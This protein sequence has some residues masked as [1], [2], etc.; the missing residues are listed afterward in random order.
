MIER[1]RRWN[2]FL[3]V[4]GVISGIVFGLLWKL[5]GSSWAEAIL[6]GAG[7]GFLVVVGRQLVLIALA[8]SAERDARVR[9]QG[10]EHEWISAA[11]IAQRLGVQEK[12]VWT[13]AA[14]GQIPYVKI[15]H[16]LLGIFQTSHRFRR[17]E[18][19]AWMRASAKD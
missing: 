16:G 7:F 8:R 11:E 12:W 15:E 5:F 1:F 6:L 9:A 10:T 2:S 4:R 17:D 13:M 19:E 14:R 3:L 18:V